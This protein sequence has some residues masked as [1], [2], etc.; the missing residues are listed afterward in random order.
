MSL[1]LTV[2]W[3]LRG[4]PWYLFFIGVIKKMPKYIII[5]YKKD[6]ISSFY[7]LFRYFIDDSQGGGG[8]WMVGWLDFWIFGLL[9]FWIVGLLDGWMV[10]WLDGWSIGLLDCWMVGWL[11]FGFKDCCI[12]L[13]WRSKRRV[14]RN[15]KRC[16][17]LIFCPWHALLRGV[18]RCISWRL[19]R[20]LHLLQG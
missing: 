14:V 7:D 11:G 10:G 1:Y 6:R 15:L 18:P 9:D 17:V 2:P 5:F 4:R 8:C 19:I 20:L 16:V 3:R 13:R 12:R